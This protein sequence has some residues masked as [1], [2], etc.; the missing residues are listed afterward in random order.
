MTET[1]GGYL[2]PISGRL[3]LFAT[4]V[5][6]PQLWQKYLEGARE[7]YR[8]H[9]VEYA[10]DYEGVRN[11]ASTALFVAA[12]ET[13]GRIIGGLRVQGPYAQATQA[14]AIQEW[15]ERDG[16]EELRRQLAVRLDDGVIEI[17]AA[18]V[19]PDIDCHHEISD[20]L[21]RV[22]VHSL[23]V[24][25]VRYA[26]CTAATHA[27]PRWQ[28][29]GGVVSTEVAPVAYPDERYQTRL[30]WWDRQ[31]MFESI[32]DRQIHALVVESGQLPARL[33]PVAT[34]VPSEAA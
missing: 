4:P 24:M 13:D 31:S 34:G 7:T 20:A 14:S 19:D 9:G 15:A 28:S 25:R 22:F 33:T 5:A 2:D 18:W 12:L 6:H 29:T 23:N 8:R 3:I 10:L 30:M 32:A 26:F 21:A 16:A 17:K 11:G 1:Y 27:I